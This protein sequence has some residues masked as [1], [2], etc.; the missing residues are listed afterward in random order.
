MNLK[1]VLILFGE[2]IKA[3]QTIL[4]LYTGVLSYLI[5]VF[6]LVIEINW[7][8]LLHLAISLYL[9]VSGTTVLNMY[10]D[11]DIDAIMERTKDRPLPSGKVTSSTVLIV[12]TVLT[13]TGVVLAFLTLNWVT[14]LII[15]LG[16]FVDVVV[17]SI[18]LKRRTKYSILF[19]GI[20]GGLP[21]WAGRTAILGSIP[22]IEFFG[23]DWI[24]FLFLIFILAWIPVHILTIAL[25]PKNF[26]G[27]KDAGIP[28]WPVVSSEKQTMRVI[29]IGAFLSSVALYEAARLLGA[30]WIIRIIWGI[31]CLIIIGLAIKDLIKPSNK[32]T[33]LIF[34]I[35]SLYMIL[36]FLL[37]LLGVILQ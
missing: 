36:G 21:A 5:T 37:V 22:G 32:L 10:I 24:G 15:F 16:F 8:N 29:A 23:L 2:L 13:V 9:T 26:K 18:L 7:F 6:G 25:I 30:N 27:Y 33:F 28:M 12:G 1:K 34:K 19:G 4:L 35:A 20:A 3:R 31:L 11:R 14:A 17:Y